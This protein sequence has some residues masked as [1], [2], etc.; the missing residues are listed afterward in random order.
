MGEQSLTTDSNEFEFTAVADGD[1]AVLG[2][3]MIN[4]TIDGKGPIYPQADLPPIMTEIAVFRS[5]VSV[6]PAV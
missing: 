6:G 2:A 4:F 5:R 1:R 3:G